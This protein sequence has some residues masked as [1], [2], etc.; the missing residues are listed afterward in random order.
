MFILSIPC[1]Q[2]PCAESPMGAGAVACFQSDQKGDASLV[3]SS[4]GA[5]SSLEPLLLCLYAPPP[6][7]LM[8]SLRLFILQRFGGRLEYAMTGGASLHKDIQTFFGDIG[9]PVLEVCICGLVFY[10]FCRVPRSQ[11]QLSLMIAPC[12]TPRAMV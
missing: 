10:I 2:E 1:P 7:A 3:M 4:P 5:S 11:H 6:L 9:I 12:P 8:C